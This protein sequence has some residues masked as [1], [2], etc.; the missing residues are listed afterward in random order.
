MSKRIALVGHCGPDLSWLRT[1]ITRAIKDVT[2]V[3]TDDEA[4]LEQAIAE[5]VDLVLLNRR[6]DWGFKTDQG[7]ELIRWLRAQ[8]PNLKL[9]LV[10]NYPDA[11]EA[12]M[13]AGALPGFGKSELRSAATHEKLRAALGIQS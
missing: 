3:N 11:Q 1:S 10:S 5:G 9:M 13:Q 8:H 2:F 6:L 12:A 4:E 7:V